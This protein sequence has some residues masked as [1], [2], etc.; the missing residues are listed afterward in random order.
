L[1]VLKKQ[2]IHRDIHG[3]EVLKE[4]WHPAMSAKSYSAF[5]LVAEISGPMI[6]SWTDDNSET[7]T[8]EVMINV[9]G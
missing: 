8:K 3:K 6:F 5:Y 1:S 2:K 7:Y 4:I 9:E